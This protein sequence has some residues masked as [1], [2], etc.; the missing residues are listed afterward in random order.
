MGWGPAWPRRQRGPNILGGLMRTFVVAIAATGAVFALTAAGAGAAGLL[1]T[2]DY[3]SVNLKSLAKQTVVFND[4]KATSV[5]I[6]YQYQEDEASVHFGK[7]TSATVT[8]SGS[9]TQLAACN[10]VALNTTGSSYGSAQSFAE[11][12]GSDSNSTRV[13]IVA[14]SPALSSVGDNTGIVKALITPS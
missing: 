6:T 1:P 4:C 2:N 12:T 7:V 3:E 13:A 11:S 10:K 8:V 5:G 14:F 9:A